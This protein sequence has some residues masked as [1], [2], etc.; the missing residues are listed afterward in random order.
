MS[1]LEPEPWWRAVDLG[2]LLVVVGSHFG[3]AWSGR[4]RDRKVE[5]LRNGQ[6]AV[7]A[8]FNRAGQLIS[9][10][11]GAEW[12]P[13]DAVELRARAARTLAIDRVEVRRELLFLHVPVGSVFRASDGAFQL[14]PPPPGSP[15]VPE[16][17]YGKHPL[18]LEFPV[19]MCGDRD[20]DRARRDRR[21]RF[22]TLALS[23]LVTHVDVPDRTGEHLWYWDNDAQ[24]P[25]YAQVEYWVLG[26][27]GL[28]VPGTRDSLSP[29]DGVPPA[30]VLPHDEFY[31]RRGIG[32]QDEIL[33]VPDSLEA[34]VRVL[35][36]MEPS[37]RE[38]FLRASY[39]FQHARRVWHYSKSAS[40]VATCQAIEA[41]LPPAETRHCPTCE[42]SHEEPSITKRFNEWAERYVEDDDLR[43]DLYTIRSFLS[44]G[45][46][47]LD[48]DWEA[49]TFA[50]GRNL[51]TEL[52]A[53][54]QVWRAAR[55]GLASWVNSG[56]DEIDQGDDDVEPA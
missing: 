56:G 43:D 18:V 1:R 23:A 12:Q 2:D 35:E 52:R 53:S 24:S 48:I 17:I 34:S 13:E 27:A 6:V 32:E 14:L 7:T 30:R 3:V 11:E 49:P 4:H 41:L 38:A 36:S 21:K 9:L 39:W 22:L 33:T 19:E 47:I 42:R 5:Y 45:A 29:V 31:G 26:P 25:R 40:Y 51:V 8:R 55:L 10:D 15:D 16:A 28:A 54:E 44:H 50:I 20:V 37:R 46:R